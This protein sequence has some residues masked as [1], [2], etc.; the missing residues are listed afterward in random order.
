VAKIAILKNARLEQ[1]QGAPGKSKLVDIEHHGTDDAE[2]YQV[3]GVYGKPQDA[4]N[5]LV[6][7]CGS[8]SIVVATHDYN[9]DEDI[10]KGETLIYSYDADGSLVGKI[11]INASGEIVINDGTKSA[12]SHAELDTALQLMVTA[13]NTALAS[14][15]NGSGTAGTVTLDISASEVSE[16]KLP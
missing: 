6:I 14:K 11:L 12:V 10:E 16:V 5:G 1:F 9:F 8:N 7:D 4:I 3:S 13:F 15:L 2:L